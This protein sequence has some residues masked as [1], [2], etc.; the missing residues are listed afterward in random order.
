MAELAVGYISLVAS[1][2][3]LGASI[4][5]ELGA[6]IETEGKKAGGRLGGFVTGAFSKVSKIGMASAAGAIGASLWGGFRR[7][8]AIEDAEAKLLGLGHTTE[9]VR[10]IMDNALASVKGTAFGLD[11]AAGLAGTIVASG[12]KPGQELESVL[13]T[14]ADTATIAGTSLGEMGD[15]FGTVAATGKLSRNE[16]NRLQSRGLPVLEMLADHFGI[17]A[18]AAS[19]MVSRGEVDFAT[20]AK[21]MDNNIGGAAL[22]AGDTTSGAFKNMKAAASRF[23]ASLLKG[24]FP[25]LKGGF[26]GIITV[27]D[28]LAPSAEKV[29]EILGTVVVAAAEGVANAARFVAENWW[30]V[31]VAGRAVTD[32][33]QTTLAPIAA[34]VV[35]AVGQRFEALAGWVKTNWG[36]I[37]DTITTVV[38]AVRTVVEG[39]LDLVLAAW[40][41][42]GKQI[43]DAVTLTWDF[44]YRTIEN[45]VNLVKN[46][47]ELAMNLIT[48]NW[49]AAWDNVKGIV[50]TVWDQIKNVVGTAIG[51]VRTAI[52]TGVEAI[53][54]A[55]NVAW[56][57]VKN[58]LAG[59]WDSIKSTVSTSVDTVVGF[60]SGLG[61]RISGA[62]S[63]LAGVILNPFRSAFNSIKN[64]WNST[65]GKISFTIPSWVPGGIGGKGWSFPKMHDGGVVPGRP[66]QEV[67]TVLMAG[68]TVLPTHKPGF[69]SSS[70]SVGASGFEAL[71]ETLIAEVAAL[72]GEV[73]RGVEQ[74]ARL[75]RTA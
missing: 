40:N 5:D 60:F 24:L 67:L 32:F 53:K 37:K 22:K 13:G 52:S 57:A 33:W 10:S 71:L 73:Q 70:G 15:I 45:T 25:Q 63:G 20:F 50:G 46:V 62:I 39:V 28:G 35:E 66:G 49:G 29:G 18:E 16:L 26:G 68:E 8:S 51:A 65:V 14:V 72:R 64:L 61:G 36:L 58:E 44:V 11:E 17:T 47:V 9:S 54:G 31:E 19:E 48:G 43:M 3:D 30:R 74:D 69:G 4:K 55:W 38:N 7:L 23:G 42:F 34:M 6:P 41:R 27:L 2:R 1:A 12:V 56:T 59:T 21:V 75:A